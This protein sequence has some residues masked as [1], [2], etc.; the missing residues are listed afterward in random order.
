MTDLKHWLFFSANEKQSTS[1]L[2][3]KMDEQF[4]GLS[5]QIQ[6]SSI[7]NAI[8]EKQYFNPD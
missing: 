4:A 8:V 6:T 1:T 5:Y 3:N 7:K 2:T